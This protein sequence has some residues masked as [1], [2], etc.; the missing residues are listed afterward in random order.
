VAGGLVA[1]V[2]LLVATACRNELGTLP[3]GSYVTAFNRAGVAVGVDGQGRAVWAWDTVSGIRRYLAT[4]GGPYPSATV[5][6]IAG[7]NTTG[8]VAGSVWEPSQGDILRPLGHSRVV[9]WDRSTSG[10]RRLDPGF[11]HTD[12]FAV[13]I[14]DQGVVIGS[15]VA[16]T[17]ES[18]GQPTFTT[19]S[20]RWTPGTAKADVLDA[21][22]SSEPRAV[23]ERGQVVGHTWAGQGYFWDPATGAYRQLTVPG[24]TY[25]DATAV[26]DRGDIVG[27]ARFGPADD[28]PR[29]AV[30]WDAA[31]GD[32]TLLP[33]LGGAWTEALAVN[34]AGAVVGFSQRPDGIRHAFR[35]DRGSATA[36]DLGG[37]STTS[38]KAMAIDPTGRA[39][40][41]ENERVLVRWDPDTPPP[42]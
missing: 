2:V 11:A 9:V 23:N 29:R 12:A 16:Q 1:V 42:A 14:N 40:G 26:N 32:A 13:G 27:T 25:T 41:V 34:D 37:T 19:R 21:G 30:H 33:D 38:S 4:G 24:A 7:A 35:V 36:V 18:E 6:D 15:V 39:Y 17:G 8:L 28:S 20:V 31:T 3:E 22:W 5:Y 10:E